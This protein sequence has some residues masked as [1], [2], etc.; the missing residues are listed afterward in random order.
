MSG[1]GENQLEESRSEEIQGE[2]NPKP[3]AS[4]SYAFT[5]ALA[6]GAAAAHYPSGALAGAPLLELDARTGPRG[7]RYD[8]FANAAGWALRSYEGQ[9][10]QTELLSSLGARVRIPLG[11][12]WTV[13]LGGGPGMVWQSSPGTSNSFH[14]AL[15]L[16]PSLEMQ[17]RRR[18]LSVELGL[19]SW[20]FPEAV[21]LGGA[22][23]ASYR[24]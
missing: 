6:A 16:A 8:F 20:I 18:S 22:V 12:R 7:G 17:T 3:P 24:F 1:I 21:R 2:E 9:A 23:G 15:L 19:K 13:A 11:Q 10:G 5:L 14:P 4:S